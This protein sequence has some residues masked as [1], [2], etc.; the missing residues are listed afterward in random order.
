MTFSTTPERHAGYVLWS[1]TPRVEYRADGVKARAI[2]ALV[3]A[4]FFK[5]VPRLLGGKSRSATAARKAEA[6]GELADAVELFVE[7]D[8][9]AEAARVMLLRGDAEVDPR[10]RLQHYT[11]AAAVAPTGHDASREARKKRA[12]L[13]IA[14]AG[15]TAISAVARKDVLAAAADLE[16]LGEE[17]LA[18]KAYAMCGDTEGEARAL[19]GAGDVDKLEDLLSTQ[20]A[21][22]RE[23][24]R[25]MDASAEI[26]LLA[27]SGRRRE[28]LV[29]AEEQARTQSDDLATREKAQSLKGRKAVGPLTRVLVNGAPLALVLGDEIVVGR[30]EGALTVSS[31]AVSRRHVRVARDAVS[32]V[33]VEDLG[34]RNGTQLHGMGI[35]GKMQVGEGLELKLGKEVSLKLVPSAALEGAVEIELAGAKWIA[36][37]GPATIGVGG[38][39]LDLARDGWV[40]LVS[41]EPP[42]F[43]GDVALVER[44]TL[45]VG[46]A[47]GERR[48]APAV[49][50]VQG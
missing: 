17:E 23:S 40:E 12:E 36:P 14:I 30:T 11:Q 47:I 28:A 2:H 16:T 34:S 48:G 1:Q 42:A 18:A 29:L 39:R 20:Q 3:F 46:D 22:D 45:L 4:R 35:A 49:L 50:R 8:E 27:A 25:R 32:G 13:V 24:R 6:R 5:S 43:R 38:W 9:P 41:G 31:N 44:A 15:E 10:I 19:A 26:D 21:K 37:L 7:A 33:Y